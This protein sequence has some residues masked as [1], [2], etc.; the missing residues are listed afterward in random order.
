MTQRAL[1]LPMSGVKKKKAVNLSGVHVLLI[2]LVDRS[3]RSVQEAK[4]S[5]TGTQLGKV[6]RLRLNLVY[7]VN[8]NLA[9]VT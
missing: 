9:C 7:T 6:G 1:N 3:T 5:G 4:S 8:S 2:L